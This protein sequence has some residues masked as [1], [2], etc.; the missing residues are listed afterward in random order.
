[1]LKRVRQFLE[2]IVFAG[3]KPGAKGAKP[4]DPLYLSKRTVAQRIKSTLPILLPVVLVAAIVAVALSRRSVSQSKPQSELTVA[5]IA[6]KILP[7]FPKDIHVESNRDVQV[8]EARLTPAPNAKVTG[9]VRNN[10]E[11][12]IRRA[13]LVFDLTDANGSQVGAV[14]T[15]VENLAPKSTTNFEFAIQ[16]AGAALVLVREVSSE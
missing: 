1:M 3:M 7:D 8:V 10:T 11:R 15:I 14:S 12:R 16:H 9:S 4:L 6:A 13:R 2:S 5:E